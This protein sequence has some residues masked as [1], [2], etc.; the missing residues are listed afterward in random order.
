MRPLVDG[1]EYF[2]RLSAELADTKAGDQIYNAAWIGD[3]AEELDD[4]RASLGTELAGALRA[5]ASVHALLGARTWPQEGTSF[6]KTVI[7]STSCAASEELRCL[8]SGSERSGR[9]TRSS[10]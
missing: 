7:S 1:A 2:R 10:W 4:A 8:T 3:P 6:P 9:T 5:G